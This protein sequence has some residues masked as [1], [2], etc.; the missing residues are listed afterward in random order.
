M[1]AIRDCES[2]LPITVRLILSVDRRGSLGDA[3]E[4]VQLA[5]ECARLLLAHL[6]CARV[7]RPT[8]VF[9]RAFRYADAKKG[10]FV[11]GLDFSGNP[12]IKHFA[13]WL[14]FCG[15]FNP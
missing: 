11:V 9:A 15:F 2:R 3:E 6:A 4:A 8:P 13:V 7:C 14:S 5:V 10:G 1:C 12:T